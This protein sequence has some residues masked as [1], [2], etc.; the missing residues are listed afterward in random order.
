MSEV[1][2]PVGSWEMLEAAVRS[3]ADAIYLGASDFNARRNAQNFS[4]EELKQAIEYCHICGV[5][6]YLTLNTVL[7]EKELETAIECAKQA[8]EFGIDAFIVADLG[9]ARLLKKALPETPL[10]ASTQMTV[11]SPAAL[12]LLKKMGFSRVVLS[13][14]MDKK[15]ITQFCKKAKE[16]SIETELFIHGAL[17]MCMSGQC[18]LSSVLGGR[19]GNRG[20]CAQPCRLPFMVQNGTGHDLSLKDLSLMDYLGELSEIGVD[21]FKIEGRMKRPEYVAAAVTTAK[22]IL[23]N[24]NVD[25]LRLDLQQIF[26]RSGFTD[27]YYT[28]KTGRDMFGIRTKE[29]VKNTANVYRNLHELYRTE[30]QTV[31][32]LVKAE[33]SKEA[34]KLT[35][36]DSINTVTVTGQGAEDAKTKPADYDYLYRTLTKFGG[37]PYYCENFEAEIGEGLMTPASRL[38]ALRREAVE[39]LSNLRGKAKPIKY[40]ELELAK[41]GKTKKQPQLLLQ[42]AKVGSIP[43]NLPKTNS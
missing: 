8:A 34:I 1:L 31:P 17:C 43:E 24:K 2:A 7:R 39:M 4:K 15:S 18:Y 19:S 37:T 26:S 6:V 23:Q 13:R 41:P 30:L 40:N 29:D 38:N 32:L 3:G 5:K 20:L 22:G 10:H 25:K 42:F 33:L 16:L 11:H 28:D 36:S 9:I 12:P 14:E 21:S 35:L 27:G